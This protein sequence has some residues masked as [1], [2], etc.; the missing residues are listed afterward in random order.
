MKQRRRSNNTTSAPRGAKSGLTA[1]SRDALARTAA[2]RERL[3]L[4][5]AGV[6]LTGDHTELGAKRVK[7]RPPQY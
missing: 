3:D 4:L 7:P 5:I 6:V 1:I 2:A